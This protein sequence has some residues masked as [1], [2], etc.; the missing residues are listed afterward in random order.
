MPNDRGLLISGPEVGADAASSP[1]VAG[2][3]GEPG[4]PLA[5]LLADYRAARRAFERAVQGQGASCLA[6]DSPS[7]EAI[8]HVAAWLQEGCERIPSLMAGAE[9]RDYDPRA[10]ETGALATANGWTRREAFGV[11]KRAADRF[12]VI[13]SD[14]R[15]DDGDEEPNVRAWLTFAARVLIAGTA[16]VA[17][18]E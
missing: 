8:I 5:P 4:A 12:E 14:L 3:G 11:Y 16:R 6:D 10:F 7:R 2:D 18:R 9:P 1:R 15:D 17:G 13:A